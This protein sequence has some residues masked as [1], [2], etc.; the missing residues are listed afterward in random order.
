MRC[1]LTEVTQVVVVCM[2]LH[3]LCIDDNEHVS[4]PLVVD[5]DTRDIMTPISNASLAYAPRD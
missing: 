5:I 3:N 1:K 2:K 4:H